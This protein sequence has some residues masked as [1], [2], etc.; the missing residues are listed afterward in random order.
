VTDVLGL[1]TDVLEEH[2]TM[3]DDVDA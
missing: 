2:A 3:I 1:A